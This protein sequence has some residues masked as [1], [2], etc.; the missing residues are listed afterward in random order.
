M[1]QTPTKDDSY[2]CHFW[3]C[4]ELVK[5]KAV[6]NAVGNYGLQTVSAMGIQEMKVVVAFGWSDLHG[7]GLS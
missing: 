6:Y 1:G 5:Y 7:G 3:W 4:K 2:P